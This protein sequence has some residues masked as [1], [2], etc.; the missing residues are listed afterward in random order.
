[1]KELNGTANCEVP[2][3]M[4][5]EMCKTGLWKT[6]VKDGSTKKP[7]HRKSKSS[8][9]Y[10]HKHKHHHGHK[11]RHNRQ[12]RDREGSAEE[13]GLWM[14][15]KKKGDDDNDDGS[16]TDLHRKLSIINEDKNDAVVIDMGEIQKSL[17]ELNDIGDVPMVGE[18]EDD[19]ESERT[20]EKVV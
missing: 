15:D 18:G 2:F 20:A 6:F 1:M 9:K 13:E 12:K 5:E 7:Q 11:N 17:L 19:D 3:N 10:K 16:D 14:L 4:S 8:D